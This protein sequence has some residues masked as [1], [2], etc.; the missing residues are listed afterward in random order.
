MFNSIYVLTK[1]AF[2]LSYLKFLFHCSALGRLFFRDE[3]PSPWLFFSTYF[4]SSKAERLCFRACLKN[5]EFIKTFDI[6]VMILSFIRDE[7]EFNEMNTDLIVQCP[8]TGFLESVLSNLEQH[9]ILCS[10]NLMLVLKRPWVLDSTLSILKSYQI[11]SL[12]NFRLAAQ[13]RNQALL[14]AM[15]LN[16]DNFDALMNK[17]HKVLLTQEIKTSIWEKFPRYLFTQS[18]FEMI[19]T[20]T[21]DDNLEQGFQKILAKG[22]F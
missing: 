17:R 5:P 11:L 4:S 6:M 10:D 2:L 20:A 15:L 9:Q 13:H 22:S 14:D 1:E 12:E 16:Q 19:V 21:E 18:H 3:P 8:D 7:G